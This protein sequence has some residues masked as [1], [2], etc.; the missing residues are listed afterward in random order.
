MSG[1][2]ESGSPARAVFPLFFGLGALSLV[3]QT[4]LVR[5]FLVVVHGTELV[6]GLLFACWLFWIGTA[7]LIG[8]AAARRAVRPATQLRFWVSLGALAPLAQIELVRHAQALL[9]VAPGLVMSWP[10]ALLLAFVSLAPFCFVVGVTF[11]LGCRTLR[12][13]SSRGVGYLYMAEAAGAL[14]GGLLCSLVLIGRVSSI[15]V[16][17]AGGAC[18]L[19]ASAFL[20]NGTSRVAGLIAAGLIASVAPW[21]ARLDHRSRHDELSALMPGQE[22]VDAFDTPYEQVAIGRLENQLTVYGDGLPV[23]TIPDPYELPA[24]IYRLLAQ[25]PAPQRVLFVATPTSG[26]AGELVRALGERPETAQASVTFVYADDELVRRLMPWLPADEVR[27]IHERVRLVHD[28]PRAFLT[29]SPGSCDLI[30]V[31]A[32]EPTAAHVNRFY[33]EEFYR[34]ARQALSQGGMIGFRLPSSGGYVGREISELSVSVHKALS[35]AFENVV[36]TPGEQAWFFASPSRGRLTTD[37]SVIAERLRAHPGAAAFRD[38]IALDYEPGRLKHFDE[39]MASGRE[40]VA[41]SD[42]HPGS[43]YYG[44]ILWERFSSEQ[45]SGTSW[46]ARAHAAARSVGIGHVLVAMAAIAAAWLAMR[47]FVIR[48]AANVEVAATTAV[49]GFTS[50][51]LNLVLLIAYQSTC[52]ALYQRIAVMSALLMCGIAIGSGAVGRVAPGIARPAMAVGAILAST[53]LLAAGLSPLLR[54]LAERS[55][56]VQQVGF[57]LLFSLAGALLGACYPA[58][59]QVLIAQR[60]TDGARTASAGGLIDALDHLGAT[61]GAL[62]VGTIILPAIG[63]GATLRLIALVTFAVGIGWLMQ[64]KVRAT[65]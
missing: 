1:P 55:S 12:D 50:M 42:D 19:A 28:D 26:L 37:P 6:L 20:H 27:V 18:V 23:A 51:A 53:A 54:W 48:N 13:Q 35:S 64:A 24:V 52:G 44:A 45:P 58:L 25:A 47:K 8:T 36:V 21:A 43:Y 39:L 17:S 29:R 7:A 4:C 10:Q 60:E 56:W 11:P 59:A 33:T 30:F 16:L 3:A 22:V 32:P 2:E 65:R 57:G 34:A 46:L 63:A 40:A 38:D 5:E 62:S 31:D 41:N 14:A 61:L 49:A 15:A 9:R